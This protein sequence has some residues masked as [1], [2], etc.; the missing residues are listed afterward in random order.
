[1]LEQLPDRTRR[2]ADALLVLDEREAH[3]TVAAV[4]E[5][6][7]GAD[8]DAR[9]AREAQRE[10]ERAELTE[11]LGDRRPHEHRSARRLDGPA[12]A[13]EAAAQSVAAAAV[14]LADL[15]GVIV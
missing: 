5:P 13:G 15:G 1:M 10:L 6:D 2:L 7:A 9:V 14:D 12:G 8:R 3:V 11:A 4:A